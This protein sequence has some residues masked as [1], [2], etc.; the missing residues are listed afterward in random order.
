MSEETTVLTDILENASYPLLP[1]RDIVIFPHMVAPLFVGRPQSIGALEQATSRNNRIFLAAQ[2]DPKTDEPTQQDLY[3]IGT[4]GHIVQMLKLPDG[5]VKVLIEGKQRA[6]ITSFTAGQDLIQVGVEPLQESEELSPEIEAVMRAVHGTF[7]TYVG[8]SK[9]IPSEVSSSVSGIEDPSR[10]ADTVAGHLQVPI[11]EKQEILAQVHPL[12]R[13]EQLLSLLEQE[14][15]ILQ[16]ETRIRSR[17]KSQMERSQKEYY[18]NEQM[19][20]IQKEL[21]EKDEFKQELL[22]FEEQIKQKKMSQEATDK[23]LA[24]LRKLKMMSPMSAEASVVRNYIEWLLSLPWRKG[25]RDSH[26][27]ERAERILDTDHYG[28][29]KV[30]ERVLEYLAVQALVKRNKG[31]I[32]CLVGPPGV[33]KTSLGQSIAKALGRKFVRISLGGVRDEAE[34]R[35]HRRTYIGAMPGKIIQSLRKSGVKNPVFMLD[36]IDKMSM[37]FRGDPSSALLEVLDPEQNHNF[38]DHFLDIDYDLSQVLFIATANNLHAIP[39]P[40]HDRL[41][42]IRIEG[43]S[44]EEKLHIARNYLLAKQAQAHGMELSRVRFS[45]NAIYE[46]VRRYTRESGVR[47]LDRSIASIFRKLARKSLKQSREKN[48]VVSES[49]VRKYLGVPLYE[50]GVREDVDQVGL[51]TGLAWTET[52]GELLSIEV[53]TLP[54][55]GNLT[56]TGKLGE[57]MQESARA[58]LSYVRSRW[59]KLGLDEDFYSHLDIHIHVPEGAVPKD[60]PSAGITMAT[61]LASALT[62]RP[63]NKQLAMT[64]EVTL[65][66]RVLA[67]GGLKEKLLAAR[68]GGIGKILIPKENQKHL[69]DLPKELKASLDLVVVDHMDQ[70]LAEALLDEQGK[71]KSQETKTDN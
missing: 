64:G 32:L 29:A 47:S 4:I 37:D 50:Y 67:I 41:E 39:R 59:Q 15:E 21:G 16:I 34:I 43:Y 52:G 42:V 69:Q 58:A 31:P 23:A 30:K 6:K 62:G 63:V 28:L 45:D 9:K 38:G 2:I 35:G 56:V 44:E 61:A 3:P 51:A 17:V 40:L 12:T 71:Q 25:T 18:L 36:E 20:A 68:R 14:V 65:R 10:L 55:K 60:G 1:L 49:Q 48:F 7:E 53:T 70:V 66:G 24:E 8:L 5:T 54:G 13:L 46:L 22:E 11:A 26:D 33:G 57:V 27:L 19:R